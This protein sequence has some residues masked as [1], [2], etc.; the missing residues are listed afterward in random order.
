MDETEQAHREL[1]RLQAIV[2]R[3]EGHMFALRGWLLA[4]VGG[5][6]AAYYTKNIE[7]SELAVRGALLAIVLLFLFL[8]SRH[9]NLV[10]AVVERAAALEKSIVDSRQPKDQPRVGW[11]DGPKV[12]EACKNGANRW[13]PHHGMTLVHNLPFYAVLL[14]IIAFATVSLPPKSAPSQTPAVQPAAE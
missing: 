12:S 7:M 3:H 2:T 8:D 11:Y 9:V 4:I 1:D 14:V 5:L 10:E 6:L 13:W